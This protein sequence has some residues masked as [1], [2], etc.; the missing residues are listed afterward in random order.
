MDSYT[1]QELEAYTLLASL[2]LIWRQSNQQ[3]CVLR[4]LLKV[5]VV[6]QPLVSFFVH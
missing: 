4:S 6:Q 2:P 5:L 1:V 3:L